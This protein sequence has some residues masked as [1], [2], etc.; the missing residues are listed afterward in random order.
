MPGIRP[1]GWSPIQE[2]QLP[3]LTITK[4]HNFSEAERRLRTVPLKD[5]R[6]PEFYPYLRSRIT[7]QRIAIN[8]LWP[9]SLYVLRPQLEFL[10]DLARAFKSEGFNPV[11]LTLRETIVSYVSRHWEQ[12]KD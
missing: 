10:R 11:N 12:K 2:A 6:I 1:E 5:Q 4:T 3:E 9:C 7:L 8:Q